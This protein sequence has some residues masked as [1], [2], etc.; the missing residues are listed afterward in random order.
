MGITENNL[1][2]RAKRLKDNYNL[3]VDEAELIYK[4]QENLCAICKKA[5]KSGKRLALDHSHKTGLVRGGLCSECNRALGKIE[6]RGWDVKRLL[7]AAAYLF[8]PPA[9]VALGRQVFGYAGRVGTKKQRKS[10][11]RAAKLAAKRVTPF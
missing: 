6:N 10:L 4:H 9:V 2:A 7:A 1:K 11:R 5:Q 8:N 3:T